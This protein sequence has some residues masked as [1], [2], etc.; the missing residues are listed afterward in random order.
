MLDAPIGRIGLDKSEADDEGRVPQSRDPA[1]KGAIGAWGVPAATLTPA[2]LSPAAL[3]P[4]ALTPAG[5][6]GAASLPA[7]DPASIMEKQRIFSAALAMTPFAAA[8]TASLAMRRAR[9]LQ[10]G[11]REAAS[12]CKSARDLIDVNRRYG[13]KAISA[14]ATEGWRILERSLELGKVAASGAR[15]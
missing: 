9:A 10:K 12:R 8:Q 1:L 13:E 15:R 6:S 2:A 14:G 4:A 7:F 5:F 11:W 3:S